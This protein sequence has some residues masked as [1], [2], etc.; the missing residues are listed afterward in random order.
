MIMDGKPMAMGGETN[1][2]GWESMV[3]DGNHW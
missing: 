1:G 2:N 3:M